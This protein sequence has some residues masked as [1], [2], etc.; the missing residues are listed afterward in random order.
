[1]EI[2]SVSVAWAMHLQCVTVGTFN[3]A[4]RFVLAGVL[5]LSAL[6]CSGEDDQ[7]DMG[8]ALNVSTEQKAGNLA[9]TY[10]ERGAFIE[11]SGETLE[12]KGTGASP[13][14]TI[15]G[16]PATIAKDG[17]WTAT[18]T[19][20]VGVN[21]IKS[22]DGEF[23]S[24]CAFMYGH[25]VKFSDPLPQGI[26]LKLGVQGV[27]GK[28]PVASLSSV[29]SLFLKGKTDLLAALKGKDLGS[30]SC[31]FAT[32]SGSISSAK[33][34]GNTTVAFSPADG[35]VNV[36]LVGHDIDVSGPVTAKAIGLSASSTAHVKVGTFT[37][38]GLA[39]FNLV[40]GALKAT[41]PSAGVKLDGYNLSID[42]V[43]G[44]LVDWFAKGPVRGMIES[45]S[46]NFAKNELPK[47]INLTLDGLG[48]PKEIDLK[49]L[50]IAPIP[51]QT[52][53]DGIEFTKE[54]GSLTASARFGA[55]EYNGGQP[56]V[57]ALGWLEIS[58][59]PSPKRPESVAASV[60]LDSMNQLLLAVW[61]GGSLQ[62]PIPDAGP[63]AGIRVDP[64]LPPLITLGDKEGTL[65]IALGEV[66]IDGTLNNA[67][68]TAAATLIQDVTPS[69]DGGNLLITPAGD[70]NLSITWLKADDIPDTL[71]NVVTGLAK[72]QLGNF[73]KSL[74]LPIPSITLTQLGGGFAGQSLKIDAPALTVDSAAARLDIAGTLKLSR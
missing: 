54:G 18:I 33:N 44:F 15:N 43:P 47:F 49:A 29:T 28:D 64:L 36:T 19:P 53:F 37:I 66:N 60:S 63:I 48:M 45:A 55:T 17:T 21:I 62:R 8:S 68:F 25:F 2:P 16:Q 35:G 3:R 30:G 1:M 38:T 31:S 65:K 69:I 71:R 14:M 67:P 10:P 23:A 5:A 46:V 34:G 27:A 22:V 4:T 41:I 20:T 13:A 61:G 73:L 7:P 74:K 39:K 51:L 32:C 24:D 6:H 52:Q 70:A 59:A 12:I 40:N 9:F 57:R 58:K 72:D 50:E 11:Q 26:S 42:N 56:G